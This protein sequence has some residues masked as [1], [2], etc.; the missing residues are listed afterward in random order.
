MFMQLELI[1]IVRLLRE[2]TDKYA[3][4]WMRQSL[5]QLEEVKCQVQGD[6]S[7]LVCQRKG[8]SALCLT[9]E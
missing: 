9:N 7:H 6:S 1:K 3:R 5:K 4:Y 2:L 8:I